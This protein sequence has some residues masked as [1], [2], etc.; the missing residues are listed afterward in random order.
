MA[1][2]IK[3]KITFKVGDEKYD[4]DPSQKNE[5]LADFPEAKEM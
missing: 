2:P 4:I 1:D 3:G 5:F